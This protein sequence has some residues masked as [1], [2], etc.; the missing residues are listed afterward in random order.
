M[1]APPTTGSRC[2]VRSRVVGWGWGRSAADAACAA[3]RRGHSGWMWPEPCEGLLMARALRL[4]LGAEGV[5]L[6]LHL[7]TIQGFIYFDYE[8]D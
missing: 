5:T 2:T 4:P 7:T 8:T 3:E 1:P 6:R